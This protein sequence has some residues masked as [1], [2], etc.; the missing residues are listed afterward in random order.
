MAPCPTGTASCMACPRRRS[1]RAVS[2]SDSASAAHS[3]EYSP[4]ECPAT[5]FASRMLNP[6]A[7]IAR[8]AAIE[9]AINAGWAFCV[10]VRVSISPS[11]ISADSFSSKASSTCS[12]T[13][14]AAG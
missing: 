4:S 8:N 10:R 2:S 6:S 7:S 3:A 5:K 13:S 12:K 1:N 9:V 14:R 11:Q